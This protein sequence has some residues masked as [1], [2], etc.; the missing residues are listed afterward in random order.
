MRLPQEIQGMMRDIEQDSMRR[1][2]DKIKSDPDAHKFT[3]IMEPGR[4]TNYRYYAAKN[5]RG[6]PVRFCYSVHRNAA[7]RFLVWTEKETKKHVRR[8]D[9]SA[10]VSK[11]SAIGLARRRYDEFKAARQAAS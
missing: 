4:G 6:S 1:Q 2:L 5:G 7:G 9:F 10:V 8:V 3:R 11:K